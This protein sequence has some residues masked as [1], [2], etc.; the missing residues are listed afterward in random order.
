MEERGAPTQVHN[1]AA[2]SAGHR[3]PPGRQDLRRMKE[4][5]S[6]GARKGWPAAA[7]A[8]VE[9]SRMPAAGLRLVLEPPVT[10]LCRVLEPPV[11]GPHCR[12]PC[13]RR[14]PP[15]RAP[16]CRRRLPGC[17]CWLGLGT[18]AAP[19]AQDAVN[20]GEEGDAMGTG[21]RGMR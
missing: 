19:P 3:R 17:R 21:R 18:R 7:D 4:R 8:R 11:V 2:G 16:C 9:A 5:G 1:K 6:I 15:G 12:A 14:R 10:G 20:E 13:C